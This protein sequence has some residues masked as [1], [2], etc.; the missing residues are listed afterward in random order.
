MY[1]L[2]QD[3]IINHELN[4]YKMNTHL[5]LMSDSSKTVLK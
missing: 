1:C 4:E 3:W 5:M 2:H